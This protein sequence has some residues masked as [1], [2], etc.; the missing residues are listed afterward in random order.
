[1]SKAGKRGKSAQGAA[2]AAKWEQ[3]LLTTVFEEEK[4]KANVTF[5]VGKKA[6]DYTWINILGQN[7]AAGSRRL[8]SS[9]SKQALFSDVQELGN[10]KGKKPKETP[11]HYE[12][13]E[14]C[15]NHLDIGEDIPLPLLA[16]LIKFKLLW[17]KQN[18]LKRRDAEKKAALEREKAK[19][20]AAEKAAGGG[21]KERA[22]SPGKGKGGG[23]KTPEPQQSKDGSKLRK[24][25]EEDPEGKYIDDE[26]DDGAD[27][28]IV[29]YGFHYPNLFGLLAELGL[30]V[31]TI[32]AVNSQ[33]YA[34]FQPKE[35]D[36]QP[37]EKDEK[38]L[39]PKSKRKSADTKSTQSA[40]AEEAA[41]EEKA[42]LANELKS[43]WRDLPAILLRQSRLHDIA[44]KDYEVKSLLMPQN[45]ED[46]EQKAQFGAS[47]FEDIAC[48]IYDLIDARRQWHNYL[49]NLNLVQ[50]P[51]YGLPTSTAPPVGEGDKSGPVSGAPTPAGQPAPSVTS[52]NLGEQLESP[53]V[54]MRFYNDLMNCVPQESVSV[55]LVMNCML[56][57][58]EATQQ[59]IDP[60]SE[61]KPPQRADGLNSDLAKHLSSLAFK[62]A[63]TEEEHVA[64]SSVLSLPERP[65]EEFK[66]PLLVNPHDDITQR[67]HHLKAMYGF[68]PEK[69]EEDMLKKL[70]VSTMLQLPRPTSSVARERAARLQELVHFC[71]TDGLVQ[72]EIDR[73]FKQFVFES[74]DFAT[75][76]SNGFI[77]TRDSEGLEHT[78]VPWDDP[79]PFFKGMIPKHEKE[80][81][82]MSPVS[83]ERSG[84]ESDLFNSLGSD[85]PPMS[86]P[87]DVPTPL[88]PPPAP[89][90]GPPVGKKS[91]TPGKSKKSR[92]DSA[93]SGKKKG[94]KGGKKS[95]KRAQS[96]ALSED[97]KPASPAEKEPGSRSS[98]SD[99]RKGILRPSSRSSSRDGRRSRSRSPSVDDKRL[100]M[101]S[102]HFE[103]DTEGHTI[104]HV[105]DEEKGEEEEILGGK[106]TEESMNEIVDAQK[107]QLDQWCFAEHYDKKVLLQVLKSAMYKL[108]Y[109]DTYYHKRDHSLMVVLH[110]PHNPEFQ[111]HEDWHTELHSN[112][113][114][115]NYLD[116][117]EDSI[118][119]WLK[120][121][122]AKYHAQVL[123]EEIE[124]MRQDEESASRLAE[125]NA[126]KSS[127]RSATSKSKS[128]KG[129]R[130]S[131][132][133]R[134]SSASSN[135]FIRDGSLKAWKIEQDRIK[136]EEDEKERVRSAKR[137]KS[138]KAKKEEDTKKRP[139]SRGS[140]KSKGS[141]KEQ[142]QEP[143]MEMEPMMDEKYWPF[144]GYDMGNNLIHVSG[145]TSTLFP[146]DGG[147]I[148]T[149]R[150]E[151]I[152]GTV[153][154][155]TTVLKDDHT[156]TVHILDPKDTQGE[157]SDAEPDSA[158]SGAEKAEFEKPEK[159]NKDL[160]SDKRSKSMSMKSSVRKQAS[161]S[162]FGS[163][164]SQ[165]NDGMTLALSQ[166]GDSGMAPDGKKYEP[167]LYIPPVT[168]PSPVPPP[169]PSKSKKSDKKEKGRSS[170]TPE[171]PPPQPQDGDE[172]TTEVSQ[173]A[174]RSQDT[175]SKMSTLRFSLGEADEKEET[176]SIEPPA[177]EQPFQQLFISCPDGL[178]VK[179]L[180]ESHVGMRPLAED[181]R[182]LLVRQSYPFKTDGHQA[183][184]ATRKKYALNEV[185]RVITS[186]GTV[187]KNMMDGSVEVLYADGTVS[188][189]TGH[190]E[191]PRSRESSPQRINSAKSQP[192]TPSKET[193]D[194]K[195]AGTDRSTGKKSG[196]KPTSDATEE[197]RVED[198][199]R[200]TWTMTFPSGE[201]TK[202]AT[203]HEPEDLKPV[204]VCQASD[205]ETSQSMATR[206]DHVMTISYPDG[207][208]ILEHADGTRITTYY[209]ETQVPLGDGAT[210]DGEKEYDIQ[211]NKF[212]KVECPGFA[213]V[214]FNCMTSENLTIFG[215]GT[216][217]NIFP[218]G[219]YMLHHYEGGRLEIDTEGILTYFPRPV[220]NMEQL[221]PEREI[222]YMFC[223]NADVTVETVDSDGNV[224]NVKNNGD[225]SVIPANTDDI[226]DV[227]SEDQ[228]RLERKITVFKEHA[229]KFFIIHAD[230]S[231]TELLRY[232]E[233]AEYLTSAEQSPATA[234]LRDEL[235]DFP[236]V[237]GI[238][239]LK[240]YIGGPSERWLKKYDQ[241][242]II[243]P[244]IRCRDL[245]S[246]PP[247]EY[248]RQGPKFG[249]N[250]GQGL[251]V[252]GAVK[253]NVR[254]PIVKCPNILELR[255]LVQYKPMNEQ[256]RSVMQRGL[257]EYAEYVKS[258]NE[259]NDYMQVVDPRSDE[260][261][262]TAADLQAMARANN[263]LTDYEKADVKRIYEKTLTPP[264]PSPPPTPQPKRTL[265][266]WE[267]DERELQEQKEG[268]AAIRNKHIPK[269]FDSEF[270]KA[271]LLTQA[272]DINETVT[273]LSN[274]PRRDGTEAIRG[275]TRDSSQ[276]EPRSAGMQAR[277]GGPTTSQSDRSSHSDVT[278]QRKLPVADTPMSFAV[279]S[280]VGHSASGMRPGNPT[281]A[282]AAGQGSPAPVRPSAPTP[283]H[284]NKGVAGR[285]GNPTPKQAGAGTESPSDLPSH[286]D[287]PIIFEQPALEEEPE[288]GGEQEML[289][290]SMK[291]DVLGR[292]RNKPVPLPA[293]IKGG[294][295]GA[296]PNT[297]YI[298]V[299]D[300]VRRRTN[301]SLLAGATVK[302]QAQLAAMRGLILLPEEV[303]F[304]VLKEGNTY[305][306][307]VM[308]KNTGVDTCRF[309]IKQ[310]PPATGIRIIYKPG[311]V[312]AG[313]KVE[314]DVE[315]YAIAVGAEGETGV[316]AIRH[317]LEIVTETDVLFLPIT[318]TVLVAHEF[319]NRGMSS[320]QGG[321][322]PG[323]RLISTKPPSTTG[324]IR[325]RRN[326]TL[327]PVPPVK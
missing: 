310:P 140:A 80:S 16:K 220:K 216:T 307:M 9:F 201:R 212:V 200:S 56:E 205:P 74:M 95:G 300:P 165:F 53:Q 27:H 295:P 63:L 86:D 160:E 177:I 211:T 137:T 52:L 240:P 11:S 45:L 152:Q 256:L 194:K 88:T 171:P 115:R 218:D 30:N 132:Q 24:R 167:E 39:D 57:Q 22:K 161:V 40:A 184:E 143:Q 51:L 100:S 282:H 48:M 260:E 270:G 37:I 202:Y 19:A 127:K 193:K 172:K 186:E 246:L 35:G 176:K 242:S 209:R 141:A 317:E 72:S 286:L 166:F 44:R 162:A 122:E 38:T 29:I 23:K 311:P 113:G 183:C 114:F 126:K 6:D 138:P 83:D 99:S 158:R 173:A 241:E 32:M 233:I 28:Y 257:R 287:Y 248:K 84:A 267:R 50:V 34:Y 278:N 163:I 227:S 33:D 123:S 164:T 104:A 249:T 131:S 215:N 250:V 4:W 73:A 275:D 312:A 226:S 169:S 288:F 116:F 154:V 159:E 188:V 120:E 101:I 125:R 70:K 155:R 318:A 170:A 299:E 18:D 297:K 112:I 146:S 253:Q 110:S 206:D 89:R 185:S 306:H 43:F 2:G 82:R 277:P 324:I 156:F 279:Y 239:I 252:G 303:D 129:S 59:N 85:T 189:H 66:Q 14:P 319:D 105:K 55:P 276:P 175:R 272:K 190:W 61:Q 13:C 148:R 243:P 180:L 12:V 49:E 76:D 178:N 98:S 139:G 223:H 316:G 264:E 111:N 198:D 320:P 130:A 268:L 214:E 91:P 3:A 71:A 187:I 228:M 81:V 327:E 90:P 153:S 47:L 58:I 108:P 10:P 106:T 182:R 107:R 271:F 274:D 196:S 291:M 68:D 174:S 117:V 315:I 142:D 199:H 281:P 251:S 25:G 221:L 133:E 195:G 97:Q 75:T 222:R 118:G 135:I 207:T 302:G 273:L 26:P 119:D 308:L 290:Q 67:T 128:P 283:A 309:K 60:P 157:E 314:V 325:P 147:Q 321:K 305:A 5:V 102:V 31:S 245:T 42:E 229:P 254:I 64:L 17:I 238:T 292:P 1:M 69:V 168:T 208:T 280:E 103:A 263:E 213:T 204:M 232:Q 203:G 87:G 284:A 8:F 294:K 234:V 301:N 261:R 109:V 266:D 150:T 323:A 255:Q 136:G 96:P 181:D 230:G 262:M 247:K 236:G 92:S 224:F 244:G 36:E 124:K 289:S 149:E 65:P 237:V 217:V 293:V 41:R 192:D 46:A 93:D 296:I 78:A 298:Q 231:G 94:G 225:F 145:I 15:K 62:L 322:S 259:M 121:E 21:G 179:Y 144:H 191:L 7:I 269:Y 20:K 326:I 54:D 265:A 304:G 134:P 151:F 235:P 197:T 219:Y 210:D 79:Y 313:M 258:R 285:P 77:I